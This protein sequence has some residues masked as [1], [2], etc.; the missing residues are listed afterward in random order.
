MSKCAFQIKKE[1]SDIYRPGNLNIP[2][3]EYM[4]KQAVRTRIPFKTKTKKNNPGAK[5]KRI[6]KYP[7]E[8]V[9]FLSFKNKT[10][11]E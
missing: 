2:N 4:S 8:F 1:L 3:I 10:N 6:S 7:P 5:K 11:N 9:G